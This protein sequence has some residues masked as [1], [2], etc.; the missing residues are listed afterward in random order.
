MHSI[1]A[2]STLSW[3]VWC[4]YLLYWLEYSDDALSDDDFRKLSLKYLRKCGRFLIKLLLLFTSLSFSLSWL[5]RSMLVAFDFILKALVDVVNFDVPRQFVVCEPNN[6][7]ISNSWM[8]QCR[9]KRTQIADENE[10]REI[11]VQ[12]WR[13]RFMIWCSWTYVDGD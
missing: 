3:D 13:E 9:R 4:I 5:S 12:L 8:K 2:A 10:I 7:I 11:N 6:P 1:W